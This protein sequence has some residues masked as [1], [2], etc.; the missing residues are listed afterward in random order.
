LIKKYVCT[1]KGGKWI[2]PTARGK[3]WPPCPFP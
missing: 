3:W 1:L 2:F